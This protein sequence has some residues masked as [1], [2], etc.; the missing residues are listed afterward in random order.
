MTSVILLSES[1]VGPCP[2]RGDPFLPFIQSQL[3]HA[4]IQT[5]LDRYGHLL[6]EAQIGA[7]ETLDAQIFT[8]DTSENELSGE[9]AQSEAGRP[10]DTV[11]T[12]C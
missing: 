11:D 5:T 6:P 8:A 1:T 2:S 4:S 9:E 10:A 12:A 7:G 3:G